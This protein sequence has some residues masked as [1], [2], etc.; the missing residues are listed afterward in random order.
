MK[1]EAQIYVPSVAKFPDDL[2]A[3]YDLL[4]P[5]REAGLKTGLMLVLLGPEDLNG[6]NVQKQLDNLDRFVGMPQEER[7]GLTVMHP[8]KPLFGTDALNFLTNPDFSEDYVGKGIDFAGLLPTEL[9]PVHGRYFSFHTNTMITPDQWKKDPDMWT[10]KF[11]DVA[12]RVGNLVS[13]G[14]RL[15]Q[16]VSVGVETIPIPAFGDWKK[17]DDS[18]I[19]GTKF[20]YA[21]LVEMYP[22]LPWHEQVY[23][24]REQGAQISIDW[25]HSFIAMKTVSEVAR[26]VNLGHNDALERYGVYEKELQYAGKSYHFGQVMLE[27]TQEGDMVQVNNA[28]GIYRFSQF[29]NVSEEQPYFDSYPVYQ[30]DIPQHQLRNLVKGSLEK[31]VHFVIEVN[32]PKGKILEAPNTKEYLEYVLKIAK[33]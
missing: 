20:H 32:E 25:S 9:T 28:K 26:L 27:M 15:T 13:L 7:P 16:P 1:V 6:E 22:L 23:L 4:R 12:R 24:L 11:E 8:W 18:K 2:A 19:P 10:R 14:N 17:S 31:R 21:D 3:R 5:A 30:G 33:S 29:H